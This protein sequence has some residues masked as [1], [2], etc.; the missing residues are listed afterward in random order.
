MKRNIKKII[1]I[2]PLIGI[3]WLAGYNFKNNTDFFETSIYMILNLLIVIYIAFYF[4]QKKTDE[5]QL[6]DVLS[7]IIN[8][9]RESIMKKEAY[10]ITSDE[11]INYF[12]MMKR[13]FENKIEILNNNRKKFSIEIEVDYIKKEF[14]EYCNFYEEHI[15]DT[16]YLGKSKNHL[17]SHLDLIDDKFDLIKIKFYT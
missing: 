12:L 4:T 6:K 14:K 16:N 10:I 17:K 11:D 9:L 15:R 13:K 3:M 8:S 7:G 2:F 1:L 5:R